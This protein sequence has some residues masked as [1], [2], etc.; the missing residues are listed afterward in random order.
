MAKSNKNKRTMMCPEQFDKMLSKR[1]AD[2]L[3]SAAK[4]N[5]CKI[6]Y[7]ST[8]RDEGDVPERPNPDPVFPEVPGPFDK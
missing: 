7:K 6:L 4:I 3:S 1:V 8:E 5:K 2:A